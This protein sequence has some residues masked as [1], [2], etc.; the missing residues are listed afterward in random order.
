[1][2]RRLSI[3]TRLTVIASVA[4]TV[5]ALLVCVLAWLAVR[6]ALV[7]QV[8]QQLESLANGPVRQL[9]R[10]TIAA[11]PSTPLTPP[12]GSIRVQARFA[13]GE[14]V[15]APQD[16]QN[17]PFNAQDLEVAA[18]TSKAANYT[19]HTAQGTFRVYTVRGPGGET[20]QLSRSLSD[21]D[22]TLRGIEVLMILLV[23]GAA[24]VAAITGR[25]FAGAALQPVNRLTRA[26][27]E[28]ALTEDLQHPIVIDGRDEL[29]Q[30][31][32][33]FN[34]MLTALGHSRQ[35][36]QEL[37][38]DAAHELR[39]PMS[40]MRTNIEL[41]V[42]AAGRL[43]PT[44]L[45][46]LLNDLDRQS[47]ELSDLVSDL[48]ALARSAGV[49]EPV[50]RIDL[51]DVVLGALDR[52]RARNPHARLIQHT[53]PAMVSMRPSAI[54]RCIV[55]LLDNAVKFGPA[56][57]TIEVRMSLTGDSHAQFAEVSVADRAPVIPETERARIFERFHRLDSARSVP[58][59]GLGLAIVHQTVAAHGGSILVEPR[60]DHSGNIF[61]LSL[62]CCNDDVPTPA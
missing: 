31:G 49:D 12:S 33:A 50:V 20:I 58:G 22:A 62:P 45:T 15:S 5:T 6:H 42:Y 38:E 61:R 44:D 11:I 32:Q 18:G 3:R 51:G 43:T 48:V 35:A 39:T 34:Q 41:L 30:L 21:A 55:N 10:S 60:A 24:L 53:R 37:I 54:E 19:T 13:S 27:T 29:A 56:E 36:Q 23:A 2:R 40:S 28:I 8:D 14:I 25:A 59:S 47:A 4:V 17:L 7:H 1:M 46:A 57:Q 52:A 26:A 16:I 9:D